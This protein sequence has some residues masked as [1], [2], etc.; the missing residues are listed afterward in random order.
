MGKV[1]ICLIGSIVALIGVIMIYDAR[2]LTKIL[3]GFGDQNDA[4]LGLKLFGFVL[5]MIGAGLLFF[6]IV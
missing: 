3:F 4:S 2:I 5:T 6:Y 1:I